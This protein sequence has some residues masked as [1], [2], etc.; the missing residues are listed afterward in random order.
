[1]NI[2]SVIKEINELEIDK[3]VV[4]GTIIKKY[5]Q[6]KLNENKSGIM[7]NSSTL[8]KEAFEEIE[9]YLNYLKNQEN[10]LGKIEKEKDVCKQLI[11]S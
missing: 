3:H 11:D 4:I 7:I 1:M 10:I 6:V 5:S 8:P 9:K 2:D